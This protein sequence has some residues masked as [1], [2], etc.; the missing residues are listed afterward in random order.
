MLAIIPSLCKSRRGQLYFLCIA[1]LT[2]VLIMTPAVGQDH[3]WSQRFGSTDYDRGRSVCTDGSDNILTT[4]YF[5]GTVNFGGS[6]LTSAGDYDIYLAKYDADGN[7]IWSKRFGDSYP[8][9]AYCVNVDPSGNVLITGNFYGSIDF[10][11][12]TLTASYTDIFLAKFDANGNHLWSKKFGGTNIDKGWCVDTDGSGNVFITGIFRN[13]IDFGGG[14]LTSAGNYDIFLAKFA[15]NGNHTWSKRFGASGYDLGKGV[16]TDG[17]GNVYITGGFYYTVNFGGGPLTSAGNDDIFLAKY[18]A[19]GNHLWSKRFGDSDYEEGSS[20]GTDISGNVYFSGRFAGTVNFGGGT[21]ISTGGYDLYLAKF[22]SGGSHLWS[23]RYGSIY[24]DNGPNLCTSDDGLVLITC[25]FFGTID[26][27][28]GPLTTA[29]PGSTDVYLAKFDTDGDHIWSQRFGG[30][31]D[32]YGYGVDLDGSGD[33]AITGIF[34][35]TVDFGG[36]PLTSAGQTDIY[37]AKYKGAL[38]WSGD[39]YLYAD[40][41]IEEGTVLTV[42]PGTVVHIALSDAGAG[43]SNP[44]K[45]EIIVEGE[46][47]VNGT[48]SE[49][50]VFRST[51]PTTKED[52]VGIYFD[53]TSDGGSF[54]YCTV[55]HAEYAIETY[56]PVTCDHCVID[57]VRYCGVVVHSGDTDIDN[58]EIT[59][60]GCFGVFLGASTLTISSSIVADNLSVGVELNGYDTLYAYGTTF[61]NNLK[62]ILLYGGAVARVDDDCAFEDNDVGIAIYQSANIHIKNS[63]FEGNDTGIDCSTNSHPLIQGNTMTGNGTAINCYYY[64]HPTIK[65][66]SITYNTTAVYASAYSNP[67]VGHYG[68]SGNNYIYHHAAHIVNTTQGLTIMAED[69]YW[70]SPR[71][72]KPYKFIGLVDYI[73]WLTSPPQLSSP[74][75]GPRDDE[76]PSVFRLSHIMPNPFNPVTSVGYEVARPGGDVRIAV[77]DVTGK[78]VRVLVNEYMEPGSYSVF[79]DGCDNHGRQVA[80][81]MYFIQMNAGQFKETKK[82]VLL[83]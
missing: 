51:T 2:L 13:T 46:L 40:V 45:I 7:H 64:S 32:D 67:D 70:G 82:A 16:N 27:G 24:D 28:G 49:P 30:S 23:D 73:P 72:P 57:S 62:G 63:S 37:L 80:S 3:I 19:S 43:G 47:D 14:P 54:E 5:R 56:A 53:A 65:S 60:S 1:S 50:V 39:I 4:G 66:N 48:A 61:S 69:N 79:W 71:G 78:L 35:Y 25:A 29:S 68:V 36:G 22:S 21:L 59:N 33:V 18:D 6:P 31:G 38:S 34:T 15:S 55:K 42:D 9:Y 11:G 77:Y 44:S 41:T 83:R 52:W 20:V 8:D 76:V 75:S 26:F 12:G 81:S 10:G 74:W 17:S 58:S